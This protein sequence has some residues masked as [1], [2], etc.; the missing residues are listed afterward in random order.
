M[1]ECNRLVCWHC[2][3]YNRTGGWC[4]LYLDKP[5]ACQ[6]IVC[7]DEKVVQTVEKVVLYK[8]RSGRL[9]ETEKEALIEEFSHDLRAKKIAASACCGS[10]GL[11]LS[12]CENID[13]AIGLLRDL[14]SISQ[15]QE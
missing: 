9:C 8:T 10:L 1:S 12:L 2:V 5:S 6:S 11:V 4:K 3:W 15:K 14:E 13:D 7:K